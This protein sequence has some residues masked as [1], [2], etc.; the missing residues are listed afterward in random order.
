MVIYTI[1]LTFLQL[2]KILITY[3]MVYLDLNSQCLYCYYVLLCI[4]HY[5]HLMLSVI[6]YHLQLQKTRC[7][8]ALITSLFY[9]LDLFSNKANRKQKILSK[10]ERIWIL[11]VL[12]LKSNIWLLP[13][14]TVL[15]D[16]AGYWWFW[17]QDHEY[18]IMALFYSILW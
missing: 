1:Y 12:K 4:D 7:G 8:K 17:N 14:S 6:S 15:P 2:P 9:L 16:D 10:V 11:V 18:L 3:A 13:H 5:F